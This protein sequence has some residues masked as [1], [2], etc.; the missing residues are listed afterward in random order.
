MLGSPLK[1]SHV[2]RYKDIVLLLA[3]YVRAGAQ[4]L[5]AEG[6]SEPTLED[7]R[8]LAADL[9][10]LGPTFVKLGQLLSTRPDL[11]PRAHLE[12][13]SR[14][15]DKVEPFPYEVAEGIIETEL[16]ARVRNIFRSIDRRP[17]ASASLAQIH[18]AVL[19][20]GKTVAVKV[21]RPGL[22]EIIADDM[23][24]IGEA[25]LFLDG[26]TTLGRRYEFTVILNEFRRSLLDELD[27]TREA[28]NLRTLKRNLS[29]FDLL[30]VPSPLPDYSATRVL[31]MDLILGRKI[32]SLGPLGLNET[33]G[34]RLAGQLFRAYMK[35]ILV[36][37]FFHADPHPGNI[38]LAE[39]GRLAIID[40]GLVGRLG[41]ELQQDLLSLLL[42]VSAGDSDDA[43]AIAIRIG[44]K[45]ED[46]AENEFRQ[47]VARVVLGNRE[48]TIGQMNFGLIIF[49]LA[50]SSA[51]CG[52]RLPPELLLIAKSLLNLDQVVSKLD[53]D[54]APSVAVRR[55]S[56]ALMRA[57]LMNGASLG[58]ATAGILD[59]QRFVEHLPRRLN[60]ALD[61]LGGNELRVKVDAF[62]E[63]LVIHGMQKIANRI[64]LGLVLAALLVS[65]A[66]MMKVETR[67]R[68]L[69]Y[70]GLAIILF[71]AAAAASVVLMLDI[72][73]Y[74]DKRR[75][76]QHGSDPARR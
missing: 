58:A 13:L 42:A 33:D 22:R 45:R 63:H 35:Q 49:S 69:D 48:S 71:L 41:A 28:D 52:L 40:L 29:Q 38:M 73:Y 53:P 26:Y 34:P 55:E 37:G 60:K 39:D 12:A 27:F 76:A 65:A 61:V 64:A 17:L 19:R 7:A 16:D 75:T 59:A 47:K 36:D 23:A 24:A 31:T 9:E 2:G 72:L 32:T 4:R 50:R 74:D 18:R 15:Q 62:D 11:L 43:A 6:E 30:V 56:S 3:K 21:Q 20:S 57:R 54:F 14:L 51:I 1:V 10:R 67:F 46:F 8:D 70:P 44:R 68:I 66:L 25:V 5:D